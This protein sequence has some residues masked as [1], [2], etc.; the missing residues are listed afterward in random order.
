V[1]GLP[2]RLFLFYAILLQKQLKSNNCPVFSLIVLLPKMYNVCRWEGKQGL[3]EAIDMKI[4]ST[5]VTAVVFCVWASSLYATNVGLFGYSVTDK[6]LYKISG[7][8]LQSQKIGSLQV[9][10]MADMACLV[11][12]SQTTAYT[13][14]RNT[15]VLYTIDLTDVS[16][17]ASLQLDNNM[18]VNG[19]GLAVSPTDILYGIFNFSELHTI[20]VQT[21]KTNFIGN[22]GAGFESITFSPGGILYGGDDAGH[23]YQIDPQTGTLLNGLQCYLGLDIFALDIDSLAFSDGYLYAADSENGTVADLYQI[24][25]LTGLTIN[26]GSTGLAGLNGLATTPEPVSILLLSLGGLLIRKR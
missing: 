23:I 19:R 3:L 9:P 18:S 15:N 25:P 10:S 11:G 22:L 12:A 8:P 21:G 7:T 17:I 1:Y 6:G 14:D 16:T 4:K 24:N 5:L 26:L 13:I 20:N 2:Y